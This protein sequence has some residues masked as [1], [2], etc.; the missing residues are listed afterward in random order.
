MI[1]E[2][3]RDAVAARFAAAAATHAPGFVA[4]RD[5]YHERPMDRGPYLTLQ[6][7]GFPNS[8]PLLTDPEVGRQGGMWQMDVLLEASLQS[9]VA[10][11]RAALMRQATRVADALAAQPW[12][13]A[14]IS[15]MQVAPDG[16]RRADSAD[17]GNPTTADR[18]IPIRID[19]YATTL[20]GA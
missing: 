2:D 19:F 7:T 5:I 16:A 17:E 10:A 4:A 8:E 12:P 11:T 3:I 9:E 6:T 14:S 15:W 18:V 1:E 20:S 13:H